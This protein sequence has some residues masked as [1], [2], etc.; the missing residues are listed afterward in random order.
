MLDAHDFGLLTTTCGA[1]GW[2][3]F[4]YAAV[5]VRLLELA[6]ESQHPGVAGAFVNALLPSY[7]PTFAGLFR[8]CDG[9][10]VL[11]NDAIMGAAFAQGCHLLQNLAMLRENMMQLPVGAHEEQTPDAIAVHCM[12]LAIA[13]TCWRHGLPAVFNTLG[14]NLLA[15]TVKTA[16]KKRRD[17]AKSSEGGRGKKKDHDA[18]RQAVKD[19]LARLRRTRGKV[20]GDLGMARRAVA[21]SAKCGLRTVETASEGVR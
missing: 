9:W 11:G 20:F 6:K 16:A 2:L 1:S 17:V 7:D 13:F 12:R 8:C 15:D 14:D 5:L 4:A 3:E 10:D 21:R 18:I 19:E